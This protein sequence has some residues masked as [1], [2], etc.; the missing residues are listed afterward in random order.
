MG[1]LFLALALFF[2]LEPAITKGMAQNS[3]KAVFEGK[4]TKI[5]DEQPVVK[6]P[7]TTL[8]MDN[9]GEWQFAR[10]AGSPADPGSRRIN[11][12]VLDNVLRHAV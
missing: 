3:L 10:Q 2:T 12:I 5:S 6:R 8:G 4:G 1:V 11:T 7:Y 9:E